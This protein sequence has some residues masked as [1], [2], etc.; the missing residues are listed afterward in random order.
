MFLNL[1]QHNLKQVKENNNFERWTGMRSPFILLG[2]LALFVLA[3]GACQHDPIIPDGYIPPI[4]PPDTPDVPLPTR[5]CDPDTVYFLN[6]ILPLLNSSCAIPGC[7]D[8]AT[9]SDGVVLSNYN[10]IINTADVRPGNPGGSDLYEVITDSDPDDRMPP[11][12]SGVSPLTPDQIMDIFIWINQGALNNGCDGC[13]TADV[14]FSASVFPLI[15]THCTGCHS[16]PTP[17][18]GLSLTNYAQISSTANSGL[19]IHAVEGTGGITPM[20]LYQPSLSDCAI[21]TLKI[22]I[23]DGSPDN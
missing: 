7:H 8:P 21:R 23:A 2:A 4:D 1:P 10:S 11:P 14:T 22:W 15:Q 18:G 5:E 3:L 19:L 20:P 17:Q 16:G 13:D 6:D 9:A 12:G